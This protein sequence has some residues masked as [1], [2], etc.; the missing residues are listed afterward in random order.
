[1]TGELILFEG[2]EVR[3]NEQDGE[4]WL[5]LIDLAGAWGLDR[6]TLPKHI[7]RNTDF[8]EGCSKVVDILSHDGS[9]LETQEC[10][11][12]EG[13]YLLLAR[14]SKGKVK[15]PAIKESITRFRKMV[16]KLIQSERKK[17]IIQTLIAPSINTEMQLAR[18]LAEQTGG[19]LRAFQKIALGKCGHA[20]YAPALDETPHI[21]KGELGWFTPTQLAAMLHD[22]MINAE[23]LNHYLNN[24]PRDP[25]R[26]PFQYR[27]ENRLWRLTPLGMEHGREYPFHGQGGHVEPRIEWRE[28]ILVASGLKRAIDESQIS[29]PVRA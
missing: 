15:N 11:N 29:L 14:V 19:N 4:V 27:D 24:N 6:T 10:V 7:E 20:D 1:M 26:R 17:E 2:K 23:R 22:P 9:K 8:F 18:E 13:L 25:E 28:S 16:P 12:E 3:T 5:P 21:V